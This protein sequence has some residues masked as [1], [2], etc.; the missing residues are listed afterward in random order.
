MSKLKELVEK[1]TPGPWHSCGI[2]KCTIYDKFELRVANSFER[3]PATQRSDA[4]CR[5]NASLI[6]KAPELAALVVELAAAVRARNAAATVTDAYHAECLAAE[7]LAKVK[8]LE[9][10]L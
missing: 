6:A 3:V 4:E 8:A 1:A 2:N 10:S 5:A 7:A 9:E